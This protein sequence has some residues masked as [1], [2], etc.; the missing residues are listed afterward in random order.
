MFIEPEFHYLNA[1]KDKSSV[2]K[3]LWDVYIQ[4]LKDRKNLKKLDCFHTTLRVWRESSKYP[5]EFLNG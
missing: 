2:E 5:S 4:L 3:Q 1:T